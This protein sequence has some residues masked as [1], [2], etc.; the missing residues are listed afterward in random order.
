MNTKTKRTDQN[1]VED[2]QQC[3]EEYTRITARLKQSIA[4]VEHAVAFAKVDA[5]RVFQEIDKHMKRANEIAKHL[6]PENDQAEWCHSVS[7]LM[8]AMERPG[9]LMETLTALGI[10]VGRRPSGAGLE[11]LFGD[12]PKTV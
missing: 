11:W 9:E 4:L 5:L 6:A 3:P 7:A 1:R 12:E 8:D 2:H 10:V